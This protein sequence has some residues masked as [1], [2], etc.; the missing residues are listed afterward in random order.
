MSVVGMNGGTGEGGGAPPGDAGG[1]ADTLCDVFG[2]LRNI[3]P[4]E[5]A[6]I[7]ILVWIDIQ[8]KSTPE[9]IWMAQAESHFAELE[10][11]VA[12]SSL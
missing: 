9:N 8:Q 6:I 5:I 7:G 12:R 4:N 2:Y 11:D 1:G 3:G 10:I